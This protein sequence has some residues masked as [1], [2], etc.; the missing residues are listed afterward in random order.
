MI[1]RGRAGYSN[2]TALVTKL[3]KYH[4]RPCTHL[5]ALRICDWPRVKSKPLIFGRPMDSYEPLSGSGAVQPA[6]EFATCHSR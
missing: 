6:R 4:R 1:E 3:R 5:G 2:S